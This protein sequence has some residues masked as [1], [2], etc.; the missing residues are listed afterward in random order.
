MK[1]QKEQ[2]EDGISSQN[3]RLIKQISEIYNK[4][5]NRVNNIAYLTD[6]YQEPFDESVGKMYEIYKTM[7]PE[8]MLSITYRIYIKP[9]N[10][11]EKDK[12]VVFLQKLIFD[13]KH[14]FS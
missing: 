6:F 12:A 5:V 1:K 14:L 13:Y 11:I 10:D 4:P 2:L 7:Q 3:W 9:K 8:R